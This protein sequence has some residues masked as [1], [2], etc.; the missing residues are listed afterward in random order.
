M[1]VSGWFGVIVAMAALPGVAATRGETAA[2]SRPGACVD[3]VLE[4]EINAG[5]TWVQ[6]FGEGL[7]L[8]LE[9]LPSGW[10]LRVLPTQSARPSH[11]YA[12]LATPPYQSV[13]PLLL[14]TDFSLR[15]QDAV[16]WNP[17]RFRF[18]PNA[19]AYRQLLKAHEA[20]RSTPTPTAASQQELAGV[21]S[22]M[23]EGTLE[24]LDAR[25]VPGTA[26]QS[27]AASAVA[28]HFETTAHHLDQPAGGRATPLGRI[29]WVRFRIRLELPPGFRA[30][31]T[32]RL[33]RHPCR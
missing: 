27:R 15:A 25:L 30:D 8:M 9:P 18:A 17:R 2:A 26:D 16:G 12:E 5:Q 31:R 23:P 7:E 22:R 21:V 19:V 32:L 10:I 1:R 28:L 29:N 4:G 6:P 13:S 14:S 20:Y 33:E 11:D 24:I 3:V